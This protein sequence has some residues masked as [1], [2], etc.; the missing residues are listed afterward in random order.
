M[1]LEQHH[2]REIT[3][4]HFFANTGVGLGSVGVLALSHPAGIPYAL[5]IAGGPLL[6]VPLA[7]ITAWPSLGSALARIGVGRL[8]EETA[9][10][11]ALAALA[12]PALTAAR[13][14]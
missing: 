3:R 11:S 2:L 12:L 13:T 10:P 7:V 8:P 6:A 1:N 9:P 14:A 5:L 4:R